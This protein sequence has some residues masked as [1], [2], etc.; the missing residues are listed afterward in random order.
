[1]HVY[2]ISF[3][4]YIFYVI[5]VQ[6]YTFLAIFV[7]LILMT[8]CESKFR[9]S[10]WHWVSKQKFGAQ[11]I[12][13]NRITICTIFLLINDV[14]AVVFYYFFSAF[15]QHTD[16]SIIKQPRLC[17]KER[18][19]LTAFRVATLY[20]VCQTKKQLQKLDSICSLRL[21]N[22]AFTYRTSKCA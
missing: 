2:F 18:W 1:M 20:L 22:A 13:K 9:I 12:I 17:V 5:Y 21:T 16:A 7:C 4:R 8:L 6:I 10:W 3:L 19:L 15:W 11:F 14:I